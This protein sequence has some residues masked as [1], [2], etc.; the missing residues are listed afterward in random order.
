MSNEIDTEY[1]FI[2]PLDNNRKPAPYFLTKQLYDKILKSKFFSKKQK[3]IDTE[4]DDKITK[5]FKNKTD[6][7]LKYYIEPSFIK[8]LKNYLLSEGVEC[9]V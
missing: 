1:E 5:M 7:I 6:Y 9:R 3:Q 4:Y 8:E 2:I